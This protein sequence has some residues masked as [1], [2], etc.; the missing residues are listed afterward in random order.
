MRC[1]GVWLDC[2][3]VSMVLFVPVG[4]VAAYDWLVAVIAVVTIIYETV[5]MAVQ[6]CTAVPYGTVMSV[7]RAKNIAW[8]AWPVPGRWSQYRIAV[9]MGVIVVM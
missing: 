4:L 8:N 7:L 2:W 9:V 6:R 5:H 1:V 3:Y